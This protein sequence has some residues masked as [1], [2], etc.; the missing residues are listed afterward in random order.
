MGVK[1][2]KQAIAERKGFAFEATLDANTIPRL[3]AEAAAQ[4]IE[5]YIWFVGLS[6]PELHIERVWKDGNPR[7]LHRTPDW[8]KPIV[9]AALK[10]RSL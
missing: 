3:L 1:L 4:G 5:I 6:S 2:L 7:N 8:A 10:L 9:A